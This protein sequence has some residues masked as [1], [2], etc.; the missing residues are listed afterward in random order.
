MVDTVG[1]EPA[2]SRV[3]SERS[4]QLSYVSKTIYGDPDE[5]RTRVAAVKGRRLNLLTTGPKQKDGSGS[6]SRIRTN[7]LSG[8]SRTLLPTELYRHKHKQTS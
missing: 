3:W 8:M 2:T 1:L 5:N 7:D 4:N 6:G